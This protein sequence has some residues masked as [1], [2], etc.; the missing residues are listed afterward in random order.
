MMPQHYLEEIEHFFLSYKALEFKKVESQGWFSSS[1]A[2]AS[3]KLANQK[4]LEKKSKR[5]NIN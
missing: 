2:R 4:Y 5:G 3:I 1:E